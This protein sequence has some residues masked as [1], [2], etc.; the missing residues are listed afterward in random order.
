MI[1]RMVFNAPRYISNK[2]LH[3]DTGTEDEVK[4]LTNSYPHNLPT[5]ANEQ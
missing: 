1:L 2:T 4:R 3:D 5:H